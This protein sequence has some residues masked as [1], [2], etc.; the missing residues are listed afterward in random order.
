MTTLKKQTIFTYLK[1]E[2]KFSGSVIKHKSIVLDNLV[3]DKGVLLDG[4]P[5]EKLNGIWVYTAQ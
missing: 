3:P 5:V 2:G 4:R 1:P